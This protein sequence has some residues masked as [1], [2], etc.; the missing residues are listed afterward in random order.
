MSNAKHNDTEY[1]VKNISE[2]RATVC[3]PSESVIRWWGP[4][5]IEVGERIWHNGL[6]VK[7]PG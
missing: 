2:N 4:S 7:V 6:L 3:L 5:G 1:A